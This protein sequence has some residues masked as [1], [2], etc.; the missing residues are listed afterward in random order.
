LSDHLH[1][2][3]WL[4]FGDTISV[5][6]TEPANVMLLDDDA[7]HAYKDEKSFKY[8]GGWV[9][10]DQLTLWPPH[11]GLWHVVVDLGGQEGKV[12]ASVQVLRG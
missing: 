7:Y 5:R 6:L 1:A 2:A 9:S 10:Q 3:A 4:E 8:L 11:P 12:G